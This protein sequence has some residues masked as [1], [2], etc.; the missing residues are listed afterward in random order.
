MGNLQ[1]SFNYGYQHS[2]KRY[3]PKDGLNEVCAVRKFKRKFKQLL[4]VI[5]V[6]KIKT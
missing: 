3:F 5:V 2:G 4:T 1:C 6:G